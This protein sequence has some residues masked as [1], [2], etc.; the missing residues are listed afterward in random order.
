M[1]TRYDNLTNGLHDWASEHTDLRDWG[2]RTAKGEVRPANTSD[3]LEAALA[4]KAWA[5]KLSKRLLRSHL[6]GRLAD[7]IYYRCRRSASVHPL[8]LDIDAH[9]GEPD[10]LDLVD[11]AL[12]L[13]PGSY[14]ELSTKYRGYHVYV[15]VAVGPTPRKLFRELVAIFEDALAAL[16]TEN[17]YAAKIEVKGTCTLLGR[18]GT[19][20]R[21]G[22]L[23]K[24]PRLSKGEQDL[25]ALR[26]SPVFTVADLRRVVD[27]APP[28]LGL[29]QAWVKA[30]KDYYGLR[31]EAPAHLVCNGDDRLVAEGFAP[32]R[33]QNKEYNGSVIR[34][35]ERVAQNPDSLARKRE[36]GLLLARTL[37]RVPEPA[38]LAEFYESQGLAAG[39]SDRKRERDIRAVLKFIARTFDPAA[40]SGQG[41]REN[42][43]DL[44]EAIRQHV[45]PEHREGTCYK[46]RITDED[47]AVALYCVTKG[48]FRGHSECGNKSI[49]NMFDTL[50]AGGV[51]DRGCIRHKAVALKAI[52][53][54]AGLIVCHNSRYRFGPDVLGKSKEYVIGPNHPG[55]AEF[56]ALQHERT[57]V[58]SSDPDQGGE[59]LPDEVTSDDWESDVVE[60]FTPATTAGPDRTP[61]QLEHPNRW[62]YGQTTARPHWRRSNRLSDEEGQFTGGGPRTLLMNLPDI[63]R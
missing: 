7:T 34:W 5:S 33:G 14:R 12:A 9:D 22:T 45:K 36:A 50:K 32:K 46:R 23:G 30:V 6:T 15:H 17:N 21:R 57:V 60:A 62:H 41:Y 42:A 58:V 56:Q 59:V 39:T 63:H 8:M 51:I 53:E 43:P 4:R 28:D 48:A 1:S 27:M 61:G 44:M 52:L 3:R 29:S 25:A 55:F 37:G 13:F 31:H 16:A 10:A 54:R 11:Y 38:E 20:E 26:R 35:S 18:D 19:I 47:L 40:A 49:Q 2:Y 24:C